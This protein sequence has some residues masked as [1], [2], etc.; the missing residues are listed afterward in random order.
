MT[1]HGELQEVGLAAPHMVANAL[2]ACALVRAFGVD[3]DKIRLGIST[4]RVDHHRMETVAAQQG[5]RWVDDSKAT[6]A[7][8]ADASLG[9]FDS[10]V[11]IVGGLLKGTELGPLV[12]K[13]ARR[14]K[15]A[16]VIGAN[17]QPVVETFGRHAPA[18]PVFEVTATETGDVM[19]EAVR[20]AAAV[21]GGDDVVLLAPAAASMDQFTDYAD[22]GNRFA[23]AVRDH[24]G[25]AADDDDASDPRTPAR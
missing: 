17:R 7:H 1:T 25:G 10:V 15:A 20:L 16:I 23:A 13:H 5:L 11:W 21:A 6:N 14:L 3:A 4:F 24:L 19:P 8:A 9:A 18:V 2:A 22:R 12:D